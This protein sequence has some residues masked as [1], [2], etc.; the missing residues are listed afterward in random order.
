MPELPEVE[1]IVRGLAPKI[2]GQKIR[3]LKIYY[4]KIVRE[5]PAI[6]QK[7]VL[8]QKIEKIWRYGK[9]IFLDL[10]ND[11][12]IGLHLRMTGQLI[13]V[14]R[15]YPADK[16]THLELYFDTFKLIYRDVR[17]FG[18][19]ELIQTKQVLEYIKQKKLATDALEITEVEFSKNLT[20]KKTYLKAALLDQTIIA[21]LG[22]I[23]VDETLMREKLSPKFPVAKLSQSQIRSLLKTAKQVLKE[24]ILSKGTSIV[25]YV[26]SDGS[27][28]NF[29]V[30]LRA[31]K[32]SGQPCYHCGTL[33]V[34]EKIAGRGTYF[35][36]KCQAPCA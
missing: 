32:Q 31:Y 11:Y 6:F 5:N 35:C 27:T 25:D 7:K 19:F 28:G 14:E 17:K 34:R 24:A 8:Q 18:R 13:W 1:T 16:H 30:K 10:D 23:Y 36:P 3:D 4:P 21:G 22:N 26:T 29:Q 15:V 2:E 33:I 20:R 12:T 9:Y